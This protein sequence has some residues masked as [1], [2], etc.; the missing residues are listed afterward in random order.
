MQNGM[1]GLERTTTTQSV[2][3][4]IRARILSGELP[5]N[6]KLDEAALARELGVSRTPLREALAGLERDGLIR[7]EPYCGRIV[8]A[9]EDAV[10]EELFPVIGAL[11]ALAVRSTPAYAAATLDKLDALNARMA[12]PRTSARTRHGLDQDWHATLVS[13]C[14]NARLIELLTRQRALATRYDGGADRGMADVAGS[15][16]D[17][18]AVVA[19]LR[20]GKRDQAARRAEKHWNNGI[21]IIKS[22][23]AAT[24]T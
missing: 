16:E 6:A 23:R 21:G 11:E 17:H 4:R 22:W 19:A 8:A 20:A 13:D 2:L 14:A 10:V 18:A 3:L 24:S 12:R 7:H 15:T 9:A 1:T 5:A